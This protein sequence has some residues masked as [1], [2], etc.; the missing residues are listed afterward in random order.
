MDE[1]LVCIGYKSKVVAE[2]ISNI[3]NLVDLTDFRKDHIL[4]SHKYGADKPEFLQDCSGEIIFYYVS[5]VATD[6]MTGKCPP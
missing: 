5:D 4:N 3:D 1:L 6:P 2:L